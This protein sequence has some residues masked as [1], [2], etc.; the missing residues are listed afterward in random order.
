ML[1]YQRVCSSK[2][3]SIFVLG[4]I[5][6]SQPGWFDG[7]CREI[8]ISISYGFEAKNNRGMMSISQEP[9]E[10]YSET[11]LVDDYSGLSK[12]EHSQEEAEPGRNSDVEKVRREK[13]RDGESQKRRCRCAKR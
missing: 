10:Q 12:E 6:T 5:E 8:E 13:I 9:I 11:L 4:G 7:L 3:T 1:V 2:W